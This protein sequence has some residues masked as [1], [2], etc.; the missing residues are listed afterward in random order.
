MF[1]ANSKW[2]TTS[3]EAIFSLA[4]D[5]NF[6]ILILLTGSVGPLVS[7]NTARIDEVLDDRKFDVLR[8]V[9]DEW[10]AKG[11]KIF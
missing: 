3:M 4:A 2:K 8:N 1:W 6:K 7:Q 10:E 11:F 5:N 9:D